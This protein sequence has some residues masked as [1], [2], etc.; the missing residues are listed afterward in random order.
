MARS[1]HKRRRAARLKDPE[2]RAEYERAS[3]EIAQIDAVLQTL[4]DL[5]EGAGLSKAE[6]ARR[7]GKNHASVRRMFTA[8]VNPELKTIVALAHALNAEVRIVPKA[9]KPTRSR[10]SR[11]KAG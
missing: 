1:Y 3:A 8:E 5:R 4:D 11:S 10:R 6:I 2:F 7:I 9:N